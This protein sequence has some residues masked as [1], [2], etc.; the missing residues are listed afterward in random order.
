M[1]THLLILILFINVNCF[2]QKF[3]QHQFNYIT[4]PY[5]SNLFE[6]ELSRINSIDFEVSTSN[7]KLQINALHRLGFK[8]FVLNSGVMTWLYL[9][10][11]G[12]GLFYQSFNASQEQII[13]N[14]NIIKKGYGLQDFR[15]LLK[16]T[17]SL[18]MSIKGPD[19]TLLNGSIPDLRSD[20]DS[21]I[22]F[23]NNEI[24]YNAILYR[25]TAKKD[26]FSISKLLQLDDTSIFAIQIQGEQIYIA[27]KK[28]F[29]IVNKLS[30]KI[31][32]E[33]DNIFWGQSY[34]NS[35]AI[36][37]KNE[38]YVGMRSAYAKINPQ[39]KQIEFYFYQ[40]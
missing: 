15:F 38:V 32:Q 24:K 10:V 14:G 3:D 9:A 8:R 18:F 27:T 11:H 16:E 35:F 28:N 29:Y 2:G 39:L 19:F 37:N 40:Y 34:P 1:K 23:Q 4:P 33:I 5:Q 21:Y 26:T 6:K 30:G 20:S 7:G 25:L 12:G 17:D 31:E 13:V 22:F 36:L